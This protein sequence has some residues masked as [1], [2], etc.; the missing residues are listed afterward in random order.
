MLSL[1]L[2]LFLVLHDCCQSVGNLWI[3][4]KV[5]HV[6]DQGVKGFILPKGISTIIG[7][8][9]IVLVSVNVLVIGLVALIVAIIIASL[10]DLIG[11]ERLV[12]TATAL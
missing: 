10:Q 3:L 4:I 1:A 7:R 5:R 6:L 2:A 11:G 12:T 9:L 8:R